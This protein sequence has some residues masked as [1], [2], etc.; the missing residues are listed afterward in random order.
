MHSIK[1]NFI[2]SIEILPI[3]I[4]TS[5]IKSIGLITL[6]LVLSQINSQI[7]ACLYSWILSVTPLLLP[8]DDILGLPMV[9][10]E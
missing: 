10:H 9:Q 5:S 8:Q 1:V 6:L 4:I 3:F 7:S 2:F